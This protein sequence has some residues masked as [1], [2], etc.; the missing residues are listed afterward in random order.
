MKTILHVVEIAAE[1]ADLYRALTTGDGLAGWWTTTVTADERVGGVVHFSFQADFN[2]DME[3]TDLQKPTVVGWRCVGGHEPW[4]DNLFRFELTPLDGGRT[5]VSFTQ[6]YAQ[7][8]DDV[9]YGTY[10]F[11]WGYYLQSLKELTETGTGRP[12]TPT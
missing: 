11:N 1:P 3:I 2:P 5:R 8:L 7:E 4:A 10:N 6:H 12:F 9:A